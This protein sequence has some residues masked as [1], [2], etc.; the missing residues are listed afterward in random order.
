M[1]RATY[2]E[3]K[4]MIPLRLDSFL[5]KT[6]LCSRRKAK[7]FIEKGNIEVNNTICYD[8]A[9]RILPHKDIV[10]YNKQICSLV[11]QKIYLAFNKPRKVETTNKIQKEHAHRKTSYDFLQC[12]HNKYLFSIGRLD[13]L[14]TGLLLFTNDGKL[15]Y[16]LTHPKFQIK[17]VYLVRT[18]TSIQ[19]YILDTWQNGICID[20]IHYTLTSYH[21]HNNNTVQLTLCEGKNREIRRV[22]KHFSLKITML[23][24]IQFA[25]ITLDNLAVGKYRTLT[26]QEVQKLKQM[27]Y[28]KNI[29]SN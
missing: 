26:Y 29:I 19:K 15:C 9:Y 24:R 8:P 20:N 7:F 27:V 16:Q 6:G 23:Q 12:T 3:E 17:K 28:N 18:L 14:S 4:T 10:K 25:N 2:N 13:Y 11:E 1:L 22:L 21:Y 5:S